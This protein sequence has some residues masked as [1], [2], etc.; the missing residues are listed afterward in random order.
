MIRALREF[1]DVTGIKVGFKPAGGISKAKDALVYLSMI[2]EELGDEWL[3][4][5][6][7]RFGASSLLMD[8]E[9]QLHHHATGE[10]AGD[11]YM[12]MGGSVPGGY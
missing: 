8:C 2:K 10:Y 1:H 12:P 4:N 3:T 5:D 6:Y 7:F 11:H 9:R